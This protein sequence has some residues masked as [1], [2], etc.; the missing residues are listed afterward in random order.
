MLLTASNTLF[1]LGVRPRAVTTPVRV[2]SQSGTWGEMSAHEDLRP[3]L[4]PTSTQAATRATRK[5]HHFSTVRL[6]ECV[7]YFIRQ[8]VMSIKNL[9]PPRRGSFTSASYEHGVHYCK[10][11]TFCSERNMEASKTESAPPSESFPGPGASLIR[12]D[13]K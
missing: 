7:S 10:S 6:R 8:S 11:P 12:R 5:V 1:K 13:K 9:T 3:N 2:R 4:R